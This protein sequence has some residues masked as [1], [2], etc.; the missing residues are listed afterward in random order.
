MGM[1]F[2]SSEVAPEPGTEEDRDPGRDDVE[3]E[4]LPVRPRRAGRVV[5]LDDSELRRQ[6]SCHSSSRVSGAP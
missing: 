1:F 2:D 4:R 3:T 6:L 5:N